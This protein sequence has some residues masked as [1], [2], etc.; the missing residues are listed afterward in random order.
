MIKILPMWKTPLPRP[1]CFG[2]FCRHHSLCSETL[3]LVLN[4]ACLKQHPSFETF[5]FL[6]TCI[7]QPLPG[8]YQND[9][10]TSETFSGNLSHL[11][12][13]CFSSPLAVPLLIHFLGTFH[14]YGHSCFSLPVNHHVWISTILPI[15]MA[16]Y[17]TFL[18]P[19]FLRFFHAPDHLWVVVWFFLR[20]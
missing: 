7:W 2:N 5:V 8:Y 20:P 11:W 12:P 6:T 16:R 1:L 19:Q 9:H 18:W 13:L 14:A 17:T 15:Q 3:F 4:T 10:A